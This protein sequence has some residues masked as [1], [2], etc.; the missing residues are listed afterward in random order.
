MAVTVPE[1][2][3]VD[4][5]LKYFGNLRLNLAHVINIARLFMA[6]KP[7]QE[8]EIVRARA[9]ISDVSTTSLIGQ[10]SVYSPRNPARNL[11]LSASFRGLLPFCSAE[12][13]QKCYWC[14]VVC[15]RVLQKLTVLLMAAALLEECPL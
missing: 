8:A 13:C 6:H 15:A 12:L 9:T 1:H 2:A 10:I 5:D 7:R 14:D 11:S 3:S 4:S